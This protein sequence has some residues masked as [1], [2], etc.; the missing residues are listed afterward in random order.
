MITFTQL[1]TEACDGAGINL[2]DTNNVN[3]IK[4]NINNGL[5]LLKSDA[6]RYFTR[7]EI[8]ADLKEGQQYYMFP[9][10]CIRASELKINNGSL[11]FPITSIESEKMWNAANVIP[12][13]VVFY[14]QKYFIRGSNEVGVW[15]IPSE[16]LPG[17]AILAYDAR[18]ADM[19]LDDTYGLEL[20]VTQNQQ[21]VTC[22]THSFKPT[23]V[24]MKL[25]LFDGTDGN[26][27]NILAYVNDQ[28][29]LLD[30]YY[31]GLTTTSSTTIIGNVPD[32][33]EEYHLAL[34]FYAL[35]VFHKLK[36]GNVNKAND[37]KGDWIE[38]HDA[39]VGAYASKVTSQVIIPNDNDIPYN[40]LWVPPMNL[41]G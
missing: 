10:D 32:I 36:R 27:Y 4:R 5:K 13:F 31:Q 20:T 34:E 15:P 19:Y 18:M 1:Y 21:T 38:L 23:M 35:Y 7:K 3:Y 30:N 8:V 16:D 25:T 2:S 22:A 33:P 14:P 41:T 28:T 40:P 26:W 39:Y 6:R 17:A 37:F 29:L 11:I 12:N 9:A 24:G